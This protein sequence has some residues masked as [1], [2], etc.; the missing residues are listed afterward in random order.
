MKNIIPILFLVLGGCS[1][2]KKH[3]STYPTDQDPQRNTSST[4]GNNNMDVTKQDENSEPAN[5]S[6]LPKKKPWVVEGIDFAQ[7]KMGDTLVDISKDGKKVVMR[8]II[9]LQVNKA[10]RYF[11]TALTRDGRRVRVAFW[12]EKEKP[13]QDAVWAPFGRVEFIGKFEKIFKDG[14]LTLRKSS[15]LR[16]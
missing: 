15:Y 14:I 7:V 11:V 16:R 9:F 6:K 5:K 1:S 13:K 10:P 4:S 3:D 12:L 8:R 2:E